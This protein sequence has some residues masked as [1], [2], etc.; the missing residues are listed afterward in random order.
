[1]Q[2]LQAGLGVVTLADVCLAVAD[3]RILAGRRPAIGVI[4]VAVGGRAA[5]RECL[6]PVGPQVIL[7][8][9]GD[10]VG[11]LH[12][13]GCPKPSLDL[14]NGGVFRQNDVFEQSAWLRCPLTSPQKSED[15]MHQ[16]LME[17]LK[18]EREACILATAGGP[19]QRTGNPFFASGRS[20]TWPVTRPTAG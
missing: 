13:A 14:R 6:Q 5:A 16:D 2:I 11:R 9:V 15:F 7:R 1:M 10:I 17:R 18:A 12:H 20:P 4:V 8:Q 19:P 3:R